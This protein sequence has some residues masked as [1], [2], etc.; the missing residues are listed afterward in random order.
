MPPKKSSENQA[1]AEAI[2]ATR[3]QLGYSQGSFAAHAKMDRSYY[4]AIERG[5]FNQSLDTIV[6][7]ATNLGTSASALLKRA[8]L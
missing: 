5:E 2:R 7:I 4:G 1:L 3:E 8:K 6:K